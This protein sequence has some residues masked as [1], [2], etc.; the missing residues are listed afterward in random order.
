MRIWG[1]GCQTEC[2]CVIDCSS[3]S[4]LLRELDETHR[5]WRQGTWIF[6]GQ[7]ED[8]DLHPSA[9]RKGSLVEKC[10]DNIRLDLQTMDLLRDEMKEQWKSY[11]ETSFQRHFDLA[12]RITVEK[13]LIWRFEDL[14]ERVGLRIP[15]NNV[16]LWGGGTRR[17]LHDELAANLNA[18]KGHLG[19]APNEIVVA[20]AQHHK[21]PTRLD[22]P[23]YGSGIHCCR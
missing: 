16:A 8:W 5:R 20:L 6:R 12:L 7:R 9:M 22:L 1:R 18:P 15:L 4:E 21:I 3:T 11:P 14:A 17:D 23:S 13:L 19:F 10:A 2:F